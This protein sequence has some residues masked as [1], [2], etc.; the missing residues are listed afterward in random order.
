MDLNMTKEQSQLQTAMR[1]F[2]QKYIEPIEPILDREARFPYEEFRQLA[3]GGWLGLVVPEEFGGSDLDYLTYM[4]IIEEMSKYSA[5]ICVNVSCHAS[6][7]RL[8]NLYCNQEIKRKYLPAMVAGK[9]IGALCITEAGA[10]SDVAAMKSTAV[11][12][13]DTYV[14]NGHKTFISNG[15]QAGVL[16]FA[17]YTDISRPGKGI[18]MFLVPTELPGVRI[19][20]L[21]EKMGMRGSETSEIILEN[22]R[23]PASYLMGE[24]NQGMKILLNGLDFGRTVV[25]VQSVG[26]AQA[27][28]EEAINYVKIRVQFGKPIAEN[29][30][31]QWLIAEMATEI[32]A[33]RALTWQAALKADQGK[34][35]SKESSMAKYYASSMACKNVSRA[36]QLHG[37]TGYVRGIK[38]ERLARDVRVTEIYEGTNEIQHMIIAKYLL[39]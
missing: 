23:I 17:A 2:C 8:I 14:L 10:G 26:I 27:A 4:L 29:Q 33:A 7:Q 12:D 24:E 11:R 9:E 35:F 22:V 13:G 32:E 20:E 31:V 36:L 18:S 19:G 1:E 30:G 39:D 3:E 37:G 28:M 38:V 15:P 25:A 34:P 5:S 6:C 21:Y 16:C